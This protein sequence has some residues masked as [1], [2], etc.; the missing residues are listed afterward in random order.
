MTSTMEV[1]SEFR[2]PHRRPHASWLV[3][4][5]KR[6]RTGWAW[7]TVALYV[8]AV[9]FTVWKFPDNNLWLALIILFSGFTA[10]VTTLGDLLVNAEE[11][12]L[13]DIEE[14]RQE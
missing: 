5:I 1:M 12:R 3:A 11:A 8:V 14:G 7:V 10:S 2:Q 4:G 13:N 6:Y 9:P